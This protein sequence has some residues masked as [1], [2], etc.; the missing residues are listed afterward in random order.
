MAARPSRGM[1]APC[2]DRRGRPDFVDALAVP[3][4]SV[5]HEERPWRR[6]GGHQLCGGVLQADA[7]RRA[8]PLVRAGD[9]TRGAVVRLELVDHEDEP[10]QRPVGRITLHVDVDVQHAGPCMQCP[11]AERAELEVRA[12]DTSCGVEQRRIE[13]Y[14]GSDKGP[15]LTKSGT[16][17]DV[18]PSRTSTPPLRRIPR[19]R[20][21]PLRRNAPPRMGRG[22]RQSPTAPVK[23]RPME[24]VHPQSLARWAI[25][26]PWRPE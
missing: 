16:R 26:R 19:R 2:N 3:R 12:D 21:R 17:V 13:T 18:D 1:K 24:G 11:R 15:Q 4:R 10:Q 5:E 23:G 14:S 8:D 7:S 6:A 9:E 22:A 20:R 25:R